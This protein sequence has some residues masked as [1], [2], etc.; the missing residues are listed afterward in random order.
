MN[1]EVLLNVEYLVD[2]LSM[3]W[4]SGRVTFPLLLFLIK[5]TNFQ[6]SAEGNFTLVNQFLKSKLL[7]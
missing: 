3:Y 4:V 7:I 5:K 2:Q 6:G 1:N